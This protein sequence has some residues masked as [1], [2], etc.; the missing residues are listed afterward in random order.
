MRQFVKRYFWLMFLVLLLIVLALLP[1]ALIGPSPPDWAPE[2]LQTWAFDVRLMAGTPAKSLLSITSGSPTDK[3]LY[4]DDEGELVSITTPNNLILA[5]TLYRP[6][7]Q[8]INTNYPAILLLHG[9]SP[10]GR[11]LGLYRVLGRELAN[12][13]YLVLS[14]DQR[15]YGDS[16]D[17]PSS[18]DPTAFDYGSDVSSS[19]DYLVSLEGVD[20]DRLYVVGHSFGGDVAISGGIIESRVKKIVAIGPGRRFDE[21]AKNELSYFRRRDMRYMDLSEPIPTDIFL[22]TR[23]SLLIDNHLDYFTE[24][25][26]KP[27]LL[28]DGMLES[29]EDREFLEQIFDSMSEPKEYFTLANADHYA[30]TVNVGPVVIYD[31]SAISN[32]VNEIDLWLRSD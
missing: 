8:D 21:R 5:G 30:N 19:I 16:D 12:L 20:P 7:G 29:R 27:L 17:P 15:G 31:V 28:I 3:Q 26:H 14:I 11:N 2:F 23:G 32:L 1:A 10:Y 24:P 22:Q 6:P 9:S 25:D 4:I 13:G 18:T